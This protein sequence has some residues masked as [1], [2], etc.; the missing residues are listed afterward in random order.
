MNPH[1]AT[2]DF[3]TILHKL[4]DCAHGANAR[5]KIL[6]LTPIMEEALCQ[7]AMQETSGARR[8]LETCA[9]PPLSV[10]DSLQ[11]CVHLAQAGGMLEPLQLTQIAWFIAACRRMT[12]YL[13]RGEGYESQ[14][15][16]YGRAFVPLEDLYHSL[17]EAVDEERVLDDASPA[18]RRLRRTIETMEQRM[19]EKL[20][21]VMNAQKRLLS[22]SYI[23]QRNGRYVLP[24]Q[25]KHQA[26][27]PGSVVDASRTGGTVFMEPTAV[28]ALQ[29]E[30]SMLIL[31]EEQE[32][33][34]VLYVLSDQ[35]AEQAHALET[36]AKLMDD[37][38]FLFAK[39]LF[40]L[41]LKANPVAI[42]CD[43]TLQL[44]NARHPLLDPELCVPL[45]L[46]LKEEEK[47]LV[48]SGPNTGGKTLALKTVG[49]LTLMAQCGLHVP[50]D[51]HSVIPMRSA[52]FCDI[53]DSQSISQNLSTFSGHMTNVI[54]ILDNLTRDSLV[55]LDE[56][57]S[58]TD[59][60]EG[61]GVAIAVLETLRLSGCCFLVTTHYGQVK[62]FAETCE[63]VA[64]ARMAF[65]A[66]TLR[67][68]YRLEMGKSG[69]SC[70]LDIISRLGMPTAIVQCA[71][72]VSQTGR[73]ERGRIQPTLRRGKLVR[74]PKPAAVIKSD[75][76]M[77][78]SV[79]VLPQKEKG[80]VYQPEDENGD[81][82][83]QIKGVK[84]AVRHTRLQLLV[85][86]EEL[87][88]PD[89]DFS[90]IFDTVANRKASHTLGRKYDPDAVIIHREGKEEN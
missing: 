43:G 58:G 88:P 30:L 78:D 38:D 85:H 34:R 61:A 90:I 24:V 51:E 32:V 66:V 3:D 11:E 53:G 35:V 22:D 54:S 41:Q 12:A 1:F 29:Q 65:D 18:L 14:I 63:G 70:A 37:L 57:G 15:S 23:S 20:Q 48:I 64:S 28:A 79:M 69:K 4:A 47:G 59:P 25:K 68:L 36:N 60:A 17:D 72:E 2:L 42:G 62:D 8:L 73:F 44:R 10:M 75:F 87:Y 46:C 13:K 52:V 67:P 80:I 71:R 9:Q 39:G 76:R 82:I 49:L 33:R 40:S 7:R 81:V 21:Q 16:L 74:A 26:N 55:L 31:E 83:V 89:Y 86:A 56:L 5:S 19:R 6:S 45:T 77:G 27:F 84:Q 50:C